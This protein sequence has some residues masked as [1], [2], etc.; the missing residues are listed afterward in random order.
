[1]FNESWLQ[2]RHFQL[3]NLPKNHSSCREKQNPWK[4]TPWP[5][6]Q[7]L[8]ALIEILGCYC[9]WIRITSWYGEY[10]VTIITYRVLYIPGVCLG[11]LSWN[12]NKKNRHYAIHVIHILHINLWHSSIERVVKGKKMSK[13]PITTGG[14]VSLRSQALIQILI[15]LDPY[16][17]VRNQYVASY[18]PSNNSWTNN[19]WC[20]SNVL[21]CKKD[22][23]AFLFPNVVLFCC[24]CV[25]C[26]LYN[27][28]IYFHSRHPS[29]PFFFR[30]TRLMAESPGQRGPMPHR[31][32]SL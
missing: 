24:A 31:G 10:T 6:L 15:S 8:K 27:I 29:Q 21:M 3:T 5:L 25:M 12:S 1:M 16:S 32:C 7:G 19:N 9:W 11:F 2:L 20:T 26:Y 30:Q 13:C 22:I 18:S 4:F 17:S 14:A 28:Y 23:C